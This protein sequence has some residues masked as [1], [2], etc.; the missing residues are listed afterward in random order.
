MNRLVTTVAP[1]G[2]TF[3]RNYDPG[4]GLINH[5]DGISVATQFVRDGF[6][7][8]IQEVSPDRGTSTYYYD[9]GGEL[10][11]SID[12]RGQRID[13]TRDVQARITQKVPVGRPASETITYTWD[14]PGISGSYGVGRLSNVTDGTGTTSFAYDHRGNLIDKRQ[15]IGSSAADLAYAYDL[16]DRVT[17]IAYP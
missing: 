10:T 12:G 11:A 7:D 17:Q 13:Y 5:V 2:G 1:D 9:A 8:V 6:G 16:A 15:T 14:T 4:D 3:T